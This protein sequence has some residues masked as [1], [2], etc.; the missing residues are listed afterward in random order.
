MVSWAHVIHGSVFSPLLFPDLVGGRLWPRWPL[1][2]AGY[3]R[4]G[5]GLAFHLQY[6]DS[7]DARGRICIPSLFDGLLFLCQGGTL[8]GPLLCAQGRAAHEISGSG[9]WRC[10]ELREEADSE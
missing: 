7:P 8:L 4:R 9:S 5:K 6:R 10:W 1:R 3:G 2:T